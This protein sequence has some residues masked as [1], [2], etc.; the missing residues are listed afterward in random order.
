MDVVLREVDQ[1]LCPHLQKSRSEILQGVGSLRE[2]DLKFF[3]KE[4]TL[5]EI[6]SVIKFEHKGSLE[7]KME[8]PV[9]TKR[10]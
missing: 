8:S 5:F 4:P 3:P 1:C 10:W 9:V 2:E 7:K 6:K